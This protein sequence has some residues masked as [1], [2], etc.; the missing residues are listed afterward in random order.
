MLRIISIHSPDSDHAKLSQ[1]KNFLQKS[2]PHIAAFQ[3]LQHDV[4][5]NDTLI[6]L[7]HAFG[8]KL[9]SFQGI[10]SPEGIRKGTAV[11]AR[12][13]VAR[14]SFWEKIGAGQEI[15]AIITRTEFHRPSEIFT[16]FNC[17]I[18]NAEIFQEKNNVDDLSDFFSQPSTNCIVSFNF[19][20]VGLAELLG[21]IGLIKIIA[22]TSGAERSF[23]FA[24]RDLV[25]LVNKI[26]PVGGGLSGAALEI[27]IS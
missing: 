18:G 16:F 5:S 26:E 2:N 4:A 17:M 13:P 11:I 7:Q 24:S 14:K 9:F 22:S 6:D 8:A 20:P 12:L 25:P 27:N 23:F 10:T 3:N 15:G 1:L 19:L 21:K